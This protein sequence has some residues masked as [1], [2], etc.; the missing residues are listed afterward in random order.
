M[1]KA[2]KYYASDP[3][4]TTKLGVI[5]DGYGIGSLGPVDGLSV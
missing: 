3:N 5:I 4:Y 2:S 1:D